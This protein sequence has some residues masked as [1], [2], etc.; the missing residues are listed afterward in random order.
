MYNFCF[1]HQSFVQ[2]TQYVRHFHTL[3]WPRPW[4]EFR[5]KVPW[6][7]IRSGFTPCICH[8]DS[9][10]RS[11]RFQEVKY[12]LPTAAQLKRADRELLPCRMPAKQASVI[13]HS[14]CQKNTGMNSSLCFLIN[15]RDKTGADKGETWGRQESIQGWHWVGLTVIWVIDLTCLI[16]LQKSKYSCET[17]LTYS[18]NS[19]ICDVM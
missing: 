8:N 14:E 2:F 12:N 10:E 19:T 15:Q 17:N 5:I 13:D 11:F 4:L 7:K 16:P 3:L 18:I 1:E 6:V 9:P